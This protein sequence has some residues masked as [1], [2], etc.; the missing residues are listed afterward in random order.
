M[1]HRITQDKFYFLSNNQSILCLLLDVKHNPSKYS[2]E[3]KEWY[4][5]QI[6]K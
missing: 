2:K 1:L 3:I 4:G 5:R 6:E